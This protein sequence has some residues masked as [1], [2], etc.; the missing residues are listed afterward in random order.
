MKD[1]AAAHARKTLSVDAI[2]TLLIAHLRMVEERGN[3]LNNQIRAKLGSPRSEKEKND[4]AFTAEFGERVSG[5]MAKRLKRNRRSV[6]ILSARDFTNMIPWMLEQTKDSVGADLGPIDPED[7][8][9][10]K[11]LMKAGLQGMFE[12]VYAPMI[13]TADPYGEYWR[14]IVVTID[15]AREWNMPAIQIVSSQM[16]SDEVTRRMY[17]RTQ[18]VAYCK[19]AMAGCLKPGNLE[20]VIIEPML[21][22]VGDIN[23]KHREE[24][25]REMRA[26]LMPKLRETIKTGRKRALE[27]IAQETARVYGSVAS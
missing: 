3:R 11:K 10:A 23:P 9:I 6:P 22:I 19:R 24:L 20:S 1:N 17:S 26:E 14:W 4:E 5:I 7:L 18:F 15:L 27:W 16:G 12:Q 2:K 13:S 8:A 21:E 25:R